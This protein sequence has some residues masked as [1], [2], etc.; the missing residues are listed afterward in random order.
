MQ[1]AAEE[2][3]L[4]AALRSTN[5]QI[6]RATRAT[7][8]AAAAMRALNRLKTSRISTRVSR[9]ARCTQWHGPCLALAWTSLPCF[10]SFSTSGDATDGDIKA[11][12]RRDRRR[13]RA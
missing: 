3:L 13:A 12:K 11:A 5:K 2:G 8:T 4:H 1:A 7:V 9:R 10:Q 6:G